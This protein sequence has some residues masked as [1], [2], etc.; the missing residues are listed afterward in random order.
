M[1]VLVTGAAGFAGTHLLRQLVADGHDVHAA[2]L[3]GEKL[4]RD[5]REIPTHRADVT[6]VAQLEHVLTEVTP[7][8]IFHLAAIAHPKT[9]RENPLLAWEVNFVGTH[10]LYRLATE[11]VPEAR[12]LFIGSAAEYGRPAPTDLPL[13]EEAPLRPRDVYAATKVAGDLVGARY[14]RDGKLAVIRARAFNHFGPGQEVG[15]V[16]PDFARQVA[17]IERGLQEPKVTVGDLECERDFLDVRDVVRA[18]I[19]LIEKGQPGAVYNVCS[20]TSRKIGDLLDG[21]LKLAKI[22]PEVAPAGKTRNN[23]TDVVVGCAESLRAETGW[24]PLI[25]WEETLSDLLADWRTRFAYL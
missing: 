2:V 22:K 18:Y 20:E 3:P 12:V 1:R 8:W 21:L 19:M 13:T 4:A 14:A 6:D 5:L 9:C 17:R 7:E 25:S 10:N 11:V 15:Y 24:E 16:A 23:Q